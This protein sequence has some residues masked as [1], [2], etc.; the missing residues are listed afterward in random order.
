[1]PSGRDQAVGPVVAER[2]VEGRGARHAAGAAGDTAMKPTPVWAV[3]VRLPVNAWAPTGTPQ[4]PATSGP[5]GAGV[6]GVGQRQ[7][8]PGRVSMIRPGL[9]GTKRRPAVP[10]T[11]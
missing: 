7:D 9:S 8:G 5:G 2:E 11:K 1:M 6:E 10:G 3:T 4:W